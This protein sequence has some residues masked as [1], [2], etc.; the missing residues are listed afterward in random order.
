MAASGVFGV[1]VVAALCAAGVAAVV[2]VA[3]AFLC[4]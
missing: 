3:A 1:V 4:H 2:F